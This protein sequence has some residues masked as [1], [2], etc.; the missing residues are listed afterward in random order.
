MDSLGLVPGS[1]YNPS[2]PRYV[3]L[4]IT[5]DARTSM[6]VTYQSDAGTKAVVRYKGRGKSGKAQGKVERG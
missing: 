4:T 3:R 5:G 6:T 1:K 2:L